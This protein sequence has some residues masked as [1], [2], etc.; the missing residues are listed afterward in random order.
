MVHNIWSILWAPY[1]Q[2]QLNSFLSASAN[3]AK[4]FILIVQKL[5]EIGFCKK[6]IVKNPSR[7]ILEISH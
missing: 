1:S 6:N 2:K 7:V 5:V 4:S 3:G